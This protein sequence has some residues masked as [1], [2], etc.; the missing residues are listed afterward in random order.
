MSDADDQA[1]EGLIDTFDEP[2]TVILTQRSEHWLPEIDV[3]GTDNSDETILALAKALFMTLNEA[4]NFD[5]DFD[6]DDDDDED[7]VDSS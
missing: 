5:F 3:A 6:D 2:I 7:W 1:F 4:V